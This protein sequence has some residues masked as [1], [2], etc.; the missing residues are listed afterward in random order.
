LAGSLATQR[1]DHGNR[2]MPEDA[3][4]C[5]S[6]SSSL[7]ASETQQG[8]GPDH[9]GISL[10][11]VDGH[12]K[13]R[14]LSPPL[15]RVF[16]TDHPFRARGTAF[17]I[18]PAGDAVA[19]DGRAGGRGAAADAVGNHEPQRPGKM[20]SATATRLLTRVLV[21][22]PRAFDVVLADGST[23]GLTSSTSLL[24]PASTSW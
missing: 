7:W 22:F 2:V 18:P 6:H 21:G 16:A 13:P 24:E 3:A 5:A 4:H 14:Q 9:R 12:R 15:L 8:L 20:K 11:I 23:C 1:Q 19:G 10:A 17:S